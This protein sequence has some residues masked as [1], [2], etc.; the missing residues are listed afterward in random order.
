L[1]YGRWL[2][3]RE[4]FD[5]FFKGNVGASGVSARGSTIVA[6]WTQGFGVGRGIYVPSLAA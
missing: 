2:N 5:G 4:E 3:S 6:T 1:G